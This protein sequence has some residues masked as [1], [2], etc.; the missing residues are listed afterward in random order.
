MSDTDLAVAQCLMSVLRHDVGLDELLEHSLAEIGVESWA[1]TA[2]LARLEEQFGIEWD[3]D[4]AAETFDSVRT[5]AHHL[6]QVAS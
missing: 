3:F 6:D 4:V 1:F 2:F 5:I